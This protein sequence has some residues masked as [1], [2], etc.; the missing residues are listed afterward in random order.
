MVEK[1]YPEYTRNLSTCKSPM[2]MLGSV[3]KNIWAQRIGG[4]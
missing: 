1:Q 3:I 4:V 2:G